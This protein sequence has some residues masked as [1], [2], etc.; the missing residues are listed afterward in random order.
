MSS[1]AHARQSFQIQKII[2]TL[3]L[4]IFVENLQVHY[5]LNSGLEIRS[6]TQI[7][8]VK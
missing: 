5:T 6:F 2:G 4:S 7:A 1:A 3:K 8:Q